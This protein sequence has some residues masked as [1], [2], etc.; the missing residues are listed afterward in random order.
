MKC[1]GEETTG[2][3]RDG[4][5]NVNC[6]SLIVFVH[7]VLYLFVVSGSFLADGESLDERRKKERNE[8]KEETG[9]SRSILDRAIYGLRPYLSVCVYT[10]SEFTASDLQVAII[11]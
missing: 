10:E 1:N 2:T 11:S 5:R 6:T 4:R 8:R 9:R 3:G 7:V